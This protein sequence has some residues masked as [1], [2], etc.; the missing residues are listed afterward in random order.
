MATH[1]E[2]LFNNASGKQFEY[3]RALR[4]NLTPAEFVLWEKLRSRRLGGFKFRRQHPIDKY[5]ADFYCHEARLVV[6]VDGGIH[7][8]KMNKEYDIERDNVLDK[9]GIT[10]IRFT[11]G[12]VIGDMVN[13]LERILGYLT[14][15][16]PS[17][18]GEGEGA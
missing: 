16:R 18:L 10:T 5:I 3:G 2:N 17:P 4:Q 14:S 15:P 7:T 11:N 12:E 8:I 13:V 9:L 6:E 1:E